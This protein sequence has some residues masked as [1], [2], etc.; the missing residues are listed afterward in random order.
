MV[1][2]TL[3]P[4]V[5]TSKNENENLL[6]CRGDSIN[7]LQ[8]V[9]DPLVPSNLLH[10]L[11]SQLYLWGSPFFFI[12]CVPSNISGV[13]HSSSSAF[14]A[15]NGVH[16]SSSSSAFP[17]IS[18]G[19]TILLHLLRSPLYF[20]GSPF[21]FFFCLPSGISGVHHSSSSAFPAIS[22][23][24]TIL[25]H[26]LAFPA[27]FWGSP[28]FFF[29]CLPSG[30]SGVHHSSSSAF[31]A[32]SLGF[33]ILLLLLRSPLYL[34]GSPFSFFF[35]V[36]SDISGVHHSSSSAFPAISLGFTILLLLRS[37][38]YLWGSPFFFFFVD[39][40]SNHK[41][42]VGHNRT[43]VSIYCIASLAEQCIRMTTYSRDVVQLEG[44]RC[45]A[46]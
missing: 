34:W 9:P 12:F 20:W 8:Y 16:H 18:L 28:F 37:Q 7:G 13:H 43:M 26:L 19:F 25:L 5:H 15:I 42:C 17:A 46:L 33:T 32:I 40:P 21:F 39:V 38:R 6:L 30:I 31:Q 14:P 10:L 41:A 24:F 23:G 4:T 27:Y 2:Y 45:Y 36:P 22:L 44:D 1:V 3:L 35:C 11:R 29:F